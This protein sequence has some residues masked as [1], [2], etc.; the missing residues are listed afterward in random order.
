MVASPSTSMMST[1]RTTRATTTTKATPAKPRTT[2]TKVS[3]E[4]RFC[5]AAMIGRDIFL[6]SLFLDAGI[7]LDDFPRAK[8]RRFEDRFCSGVAELLEVSAL[9]VLELHLQHA[10]LRPFTV[11][12]IRDLADDRVE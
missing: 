8:F 6:R 2:K 10:R 4:Q 1:T 12:S 5:V 9:D 7:R 3:P 11:L